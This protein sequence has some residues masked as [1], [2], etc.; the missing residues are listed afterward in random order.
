M[1]TAMAG[2]NGAQASPIVK[3]SRGWP[4]R[5]VKARDLGQ[6]TISH[7]LLSRQ[8]RLGVDKRIGRIEAE[9]IRN[10]FFQG[11]PTSKSPLSLEALKSIMPEIKIADFATVKMVVVSDRFEANEI[12]HEGE[13]LALRLEDVLPK[14]LEFESKK[15]VS[16]IQGKATMLDSAIEGA[17]RPVSPTGTL[18]DTNYESSSGGNLL[19]LAA[20]RFFPFSTSRIYTE[21]DEFNH[22]LVDNIGRKPEVAGS[23]ILEF[24]LLR[25]MFVRGD[26]LNP[27]QT[28]KKIKEAF[29]GNDGIV[30]K[31]EF[32]TGG[33]GVVLKEYA[34]ELKGRTRR[35]CRGT[36]KKLRRAAKHADID[37]QGIAILT[38][39]V[40]LKRFRLESAEDFLKG[41]SH[42]VVDF[43]Q[44]VAEV[45]NYLSTEPD[46]IFSLREVVNIIAEI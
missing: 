6:F 2:A 42:P 29:R 13:Y 7:G 30:M 1:Y 39:G 14:A 9:S 32:K 36:F 23:Y 45:R 34:A 20:D 15:I 41:K 5:S 28:L 38:L 44:F 11:S 24:S 40:V 46:R 31:F 43:K 12:I 10:W 35:S 27:K 19:R 8:C 22:W 21:K 16:L 4:K 26:L 17:D 25:E 18:L 3:I 37:H 33:K